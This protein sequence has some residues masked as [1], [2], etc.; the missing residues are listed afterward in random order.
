MKVTELIAI[1]QTYN[2]AAEVVVS[3]YE[4]R[5]DVHNVLELLPPLSL[6]FTTFLSLRS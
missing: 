6:R 2:P 1:L 3:T 4:D 5:A